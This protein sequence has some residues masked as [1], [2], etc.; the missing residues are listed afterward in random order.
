MINQRKPPDELEEFLIK[1]AETIGSSL[2]KL[3]IKTGLAKV[4]STA[5]NKQA[6]KSGATKKAAVVKKVAAD[7]RRKLAKS[8][9]AKPPA[10]KAPRGKKG[11]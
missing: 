6:R 8:A 7:R 3:A 9:A 4:D 5:P 2:G 10:K 11:T 1:T